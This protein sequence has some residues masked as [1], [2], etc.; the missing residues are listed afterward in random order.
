MRRPSRLTNVFHHSMQPLNCDEVRC[1]DAAVSQLSKTLARFVSGQAG[2]G[3]TCSTP[4]FSR[5]IPLSSSD[6]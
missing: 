5:I 1:L 2:L 3:P 6:F 4:G